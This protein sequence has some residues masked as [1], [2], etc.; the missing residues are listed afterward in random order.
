MFCLHSASISRHGNASL[1]SAF[2]SQ[3]EEAAPKRAFMAKRR[4]ERRGRASGGHDSA[5]ANTT[6]WYSPSPPP[7]IHPCTCCSHRGEGMLMMRSR[8][9]R[10][11]RRGS[12]SFSERH[13]PASCRVVGKTGSGTSPSGQ[14][15]RYRYSISNN[16]HSSSG[17]ALAPLSITTSKATP[18]T[19]ASSPPKLPAAPLVCPKISTATETQER[20]FSARD[21]RNDSTTAC[22]IGSSSWWPA[23]RACFMPLLYTSHNAPTTWGSVWKRW[24][25]ASSTSHTEASKSTTGW[26]SWGEEGASR[27]RRAAPS[28]SIHPTA[29]PSVEAFTNDPVPAPAVTALSLARKGAVSCSSSPISEPCTPPRIRPRDSTTMMRE[30]LGMAAKLCVTT[31]TSPCTLAGSRKCAAPLEQ[32]ARKALAALAARGASISLLHTSS[33]HG[34]TSASLCPMNLA[35]CSITVRVVVCTMGCAGRHCG[36]MYVPSSFETSACTSSR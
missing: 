6:P 34:V 32:R 31:V 2:W 3:R 12:F 17:Q 29:S 27:K 22:T 13:A 1:E 20:Q 23:S 36:R 14:N 28:S 35:Y 30:S 19:S 7:S 24:R 18:H 5:S 11:A 21:A 16:A 25:A 15:S 4:G 33:R 26:P 10:T 8:K 9:M